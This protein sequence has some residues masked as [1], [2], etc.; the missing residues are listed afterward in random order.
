[1]RV[2]VLTPTL[3]W[4]LDAGGRIRTFQL[5]REL[6]RHHELALWCVRQPGAGLEAERALGEVCGELRVFERSPRGL[7]DTLVGPRAETWFHSRALR[8]ALHTLAGTQRFELIHVD[9]LSLV[10]ALP[11]PPP[12]P[13]LVHHHKLDLELALALESSSAR[14]ELEARRWRR[15]EDDALAL[16][17][18]HVFCCAQDAQRFRARHPRAR[19]QVVESGVDLAAFA[20]RDAARDDAHLCVLG[21]LDYGPNASG[22][23]TFLRHGWPELAAAHPGLQLS[24]VG[25]GADPRD[26]RDLPRGVRLVGAVPDVRPWLARATALLVPLAIGGGTR[27]KLVEAA[28]LGCPLISTRVGAEGLALEDGVHLVLAQE[29]ESLAALAARALRDPVGLARRAEAARLRVALHYGWPRLAA[30]MDEAWSGAAQPPSMRSRA[31]S[32]ISPSMASKEI[33]GCQ[34]SASRAARASPTRCSTSAGR[35]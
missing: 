10:R 23:R 1:M 17:R 14:R 7:L 16:T 15:L 13:V 18:E 20:P 9:E 26:W 32:T 3:P 24:I 30:R 34:A 19:T 12:R 27:L 11:T 2:L 35:T 22:L 31:A 33:V 21:S 29:L 8:E 5:L 25:R 28:A 6:R 4:P